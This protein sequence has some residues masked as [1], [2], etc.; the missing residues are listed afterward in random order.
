MRS[1]PAALRGLKPVTNEPWAEDEAVY[2]RWRASTLGEDTDAAE[3]DRM[4]VD[5]TA[6]RRDFHQRLSAYRHRFNEKFVM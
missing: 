4:H 3:A 1:R 5:K 2:D 6:R